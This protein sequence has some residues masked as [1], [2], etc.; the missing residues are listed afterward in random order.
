L[1]YFLNL[2]DVYLFEFAKADVIIV[3]DSIGH[4]YAMIKQE[5]DL[6]ESF[7]EGH[8]HQVIALHGDLKKLLL[9]HLVV[10][11]GGNAMHATFESH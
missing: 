11:C 10:K 5:I 3:K 8:E 2:F 4:L 6:L 1:L 9:D 7:L